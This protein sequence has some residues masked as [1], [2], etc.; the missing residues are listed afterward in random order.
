VAGAEIAE[1]AHPLPDLRSVAA[2]ERAL[3]TA[4]ALSSEDRLLVLLSGGASALWSVPVEGVT[5]GDLRALTDLL[6]RSGAGIGEINAVR[7]H[8]SRIK[9]GGLARAALPASLLTLAISDVPDD[10]PDAIG[11]G[12]TA[13]DPTCFGD[14]LAVLSRAGASPEHAVEYLQAGERGER[15]ETARVGDLCFA[16]AEYRVIASLDTALSAVAAAAEARGLPVR[17]LGRSL[18]GEA[19]DCARTLA[20]EL[21][22]GP[23]QLLLA[24]GEPSVS[25]VGSGV[26]GR[27]QE[28][29]LAFGQEIEGRSD[30]SALFSGT[31]GNDGPTDAAGAFAD[32][33]SAAR[34]RRAGLDPRA[35]LEANDSQPLL[36]AIGDLFTTGPTDTNVTDLALILV[37]HA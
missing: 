19:R 1:A 16:S 36:R 12:P 13:P 11:S 2:A 22:S 30:V 18:R 25:V 28:L 4:A 24:G 9:G 3:A 14:A 8:L 21:S 20:R 37:G 15:P 7:K 5:L 35:A 10:Q 26:G 17:S 27:M 33:S 31:D 34:A 6:L 32:G 23:P 29:A